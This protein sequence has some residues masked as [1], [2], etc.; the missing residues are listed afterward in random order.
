MNFFAFFILISLLLFVKSHVV[1]REIFTSQN[2]FFANLFSS[3]A[4]K[5]V[6]KKKLS[7]KVKCHIRWGSEKYKKV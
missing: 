2:T 1:G 6:T 7:V 3:N 4:N 5:Y